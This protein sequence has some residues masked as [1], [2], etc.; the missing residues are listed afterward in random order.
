[1]GAGS[2]GKPVYARKAQL[3]WLI[4]N[5]RDAQFCCDQDGA[6]AGEVAVVGLERNAGVGIFLAGSV[7][8]KHLEVRNVVN[9]TVR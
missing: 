7:V 4:K 2:T 8:A 1:V 5:A 3:L 6:A 9:V